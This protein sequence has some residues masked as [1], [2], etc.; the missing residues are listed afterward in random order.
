M[1]KILLSLL[2]VVLCG[3]T[4]AQ[5][6]VKEKLNRAPVAVKTSQGIL[7]SW[8]Y[9]KADG[10]ATFSVY[11]NG[12]LV[13]SGIADVTNYLDADG[14][15]GDTYKGRAARAERPPARHGTTCSRR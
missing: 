11:R 15:G 5:V 3:S 2:A 10:N 8:R 4:N 13:K 7:V 14:P 1:K 12:T 9:L 6:Q